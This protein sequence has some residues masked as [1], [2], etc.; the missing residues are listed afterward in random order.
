MA[1]ITA[2]AVSV[3]SFLPAD[4]V[5]QR[6]Q[7]ESKY[8]FMPTKYRNSG[9]LPVIRKILRSEGINGFFRGLA[10]YLIVFGPGSA[11]WWMS[12]EWT[13]KTLSSILPL[14]N[15]SVESFGFKDH[16]QK[17][18][19]HLFCGSVAGISSTLITNP[20]DVARTRLQLFE[21][22]NQY[23]KDS[24]RQG[25]LKV[26]K[27][28]YKNE[29]LA[30][31]YKGLRPRILIKIPGSAFAFLGYEYLKDFVSLPPN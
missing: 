24:I 3:F 23:D 1:G 19:S 18:F 26:L 11:I 10:P 4:V 6:L 27:D 25:F 21:I 7:I 29:G 22:Q 30:G 31:L 15:G 28:I 5:S 14:G 2:E 17:G 9:P 12:Y 8:N 13:K 20:L 16:I